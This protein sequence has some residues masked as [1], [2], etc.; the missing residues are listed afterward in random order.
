MSM[1][2]KEP[3]YNPK[4]SYDDNYDQGPFGS[5]SDGEVYPLS[6]EPT[7]DLFGHKLHQPIGIPAGPLLNG[8]FVKAALD[9]N[10]H[11]PIYKTVRT[12]DRACHPWPNVLSVDTDGD[13]TPDK[14]AGELTADHNYHEPL[15]IT[16][17]FGV[18]SKG[19]DVWQPDAKEA[20][21]HARDGQV[22]VVS[23]QGTDW[24]G[25]GFDA[26]VEDWKLGAK[27]VLET[28]AKV[29][30]MN[31]S[32]PNEGKKNL[33]CHDVERSAAIARAV[34]EVVGDTP[35]MIKMPH[36]D[37]DSLRTWLKEVAPFVDGL[38]AINTIATS[39]VDSEGNQA[40][41]GEGR[42]RSGVCGAGIKWAGLDMMR[43]LA[44]LRNE[45]GM[46]YTIVG[47][48][49]VTVPEDYQEY[50]EAGADIVMSATGAMWNPDL[51][52]EISKQYPNI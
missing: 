3:F 27:L 42:L 1:S 29:L 32:C 23:F 41:P 36:F 34:K 13:L 5:F 50:R 20:I 19:P 16:N 39:I 47:T 30:E 22:V 45:L 15:S 33:L 37:T 10:F 46:S 8:K 21:E 44:S 12:Q 43:N 35:L 40:L 4:L 17:S 49:G 26:L 6:G 9:K 51:A 25:E 52:Q 7:Y 11:V 18:P 24:Q 48:G 2:L 38:A 31:F 28:G 14:S